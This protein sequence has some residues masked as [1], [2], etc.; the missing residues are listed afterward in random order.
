MAAV[1]ALVFS[2]HRVL[3]IAGWGAAIVGLAVA[4]GVSRLAVTPAA[5]GPAVP[6]WPGLALAIVGAGLVLAGASAGDALPRL[7][8]GGNPA[9][10]GAVRTA[11]RR[12]TGPGRVLGAVAV[13]RVLAHQR[14]QRAAR[15]D[16]R[17]GGP[18]LVSASSAS[19]LQ[20][21]TLVLRSAH[22]Q[23]SYTLQRGLSP[24]LGDADLL[25]VASAQHALDNAVATLVAPG[26]GE[27]DDQGQSLAQF[28]IGFV[29]VPAPVDQGLATLLNGVAGLRPVTATSAFALW[30]LTDLPARAR[31]VEPDGTVVALRSGP[32]SVSD[33]PAPAAGGILE[34]AEPAGGWSATLDGRALTQVPS[35]AG[36]VGP[37]VPAAAGR[38]PGDDQPPSGRPRYRPG[39]RGARRRPRGR[40][41][42][43]R[44]PD[45]RGGGGKRER[46]GQRR[47]RR[48]GG[49]RSPG[50]RRPAAGSRAGGGPV[51]PQAPARARRAPGRPGSGPGWERRSRGRRTGR[52]AGPADGSLAGRP[53]AGRAGR[54]GPG[55]PGRP[56]AGRAVQPGAGFVSRP[57]G[58]LARRCAG[59][60]L[61]RHRSPAGLAW[62]RSAA[63]LG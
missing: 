36:A 30:R 13:G 44:G 11:R 15:A 47:A 14:G 63:G 1:G 49:P 24:S 4:I 18:G 19:G 21:R 31:V 12:G 6:A 16:R 32:T 5:G 17:P 10:L 48:R 52:T 35:P 34:L 60:R 53:V 42:A 33:A 55:W 25:P 58:G 2:R 54:P 51:G 59:A 9:R 28:D 26:G 50:Q 61:G 29:L 57:A 3:L 43:A 27:A 41:G 56:A 7:T 38:R 8:G 39:D 23:L 37:G 45:K 46:S 20:L 22:G 62:R 40:A